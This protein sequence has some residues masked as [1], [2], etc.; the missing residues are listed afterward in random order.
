[1]L[2]WLLAKIGKNVKLRKIAVTGGIASGKSSVCHLLSECGSYVINAD[3]I[4][5]QLLSP[6]TIIGQK[7][8]DLLGGDIIED[9]KINRRRISQ[10]VFKDERL[11][12]KLE[13]V[14]H[15]EVLREIEKQ[16]L[17]FKNQALAT[18]HDNS[19]KTLFVAEVPLLYESGMEKFFDKVILVVA[20]LSICQQ[21]FETKHPA[22]KDEFINR[23]SRLI[24]AENKMK[25]ADYI[26]FNNGSFADLKSATLN[27][28]NQLTLNL[29]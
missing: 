2:I 25:K 10:I 16:Y 11:L 22:N 4:V 5:H 8:I 3:C 15:P 27:L 17:N 21:R 9:G 14:L 24:S 18:N 26:L 19:K 6:N 29:H 28:F 13:A 20:D 7:I 12:K 1:M 23:S